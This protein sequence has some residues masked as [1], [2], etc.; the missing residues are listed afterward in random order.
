MVFAAG[1]GTRL[2][3]YTNDR[4]KALV[5]LKGKPL[6]EIVLLRL[7]F[8]GVTEV[9]VNVHHYADMV[10]DFI[11]KNN[12]FGLTIHI[13]D[14]RKELLDTGGGLKKAQRHLSDA[15]F[16]VHNVDILSQLDL[17]TI[18]AEHLTH[19]GL[20]T[21]AVSDRETSRYLQFSEANNLVAWR[22]VKTGEQKISR[23]ANNP[24]DWAYSGIS[25]IDPSLFQ[26]FPKNENV[27][28]IIDVWLE[29]AKHGKVKCFPHRQANWLDVGKP[30]SLAKAAEMWS[31]NSFG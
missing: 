20:S 4:P 9:V 1:L 23:S 12:D 26:F 18:Y 29:A 19:K 27:F 13:S 2:R 24:K 25:V 28:S 16:I 11:R 14:E 15:P 5:E 22:N 7:K 17:H 31:P 8:F 21:L 3:P 10:I 6:L 30:E